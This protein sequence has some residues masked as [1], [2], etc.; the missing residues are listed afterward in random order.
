MKKIA[1]PMLLAAVILACAW[2]VSARATGIAHHPSPIHVP[3]PAP[4]KPITLSNGSLAMSVSTN[5]PN[6]LQ[7][8]DG[9]MILQIDLEAVRA[10]IQ[11]HKPL[12]IALVIDRSG[13]MAERGKL[14]YA[15]K[16]AQE[17]VDRLGK[18]D[19]LA[20]IIYDDV[21][22]VLVPST[23]VKDRE[24]IKEKIAG[25][26]ERGATN[27]AEGL[28]LGYSQ[29]RE[30][31]DREAINQVIILSDGLANRGITGK[32]DI[33]RMVSNWRE[34]GVSVTALGLG[35]DFNEDLMMG[36]A[37]ASGG[38]YN[39]IESPDQLAGIYEKELNTLMATVG[40]DVKI[41]INT[42]EGVKLDDVYGYDAKI[43]GSEIEIPL[44]A[45]DGGQHR[46]IVAH[47]SA[48]TSALGKKDVA[49]VR[50]DYRDM[51]SDSKKVTT[52]AKVDVICVADMAR[53]EEKRNLAVEG[54]SYWLGNS[55]ENTTAI[56]AIEGGRKDDA[57]RW[58][59][60]KV[61]EI[62]AQNAPIQSP[63]LESQAKQ[64]ENDLSNL[65][66][67][68]N[69]QDGRGKVMV[70]KGKELQRLQSL[71]YISQ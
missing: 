61:Q 68:D 57:V 24:W 62:R 31:L 69:L 21:A 5:N 50:L 70:K 59:E 8:S 53:V 28:A 46:I 19:R 41:V 39:F 63:Q 47:L 22:E 27:L 32:G 43:A 36:I 9:K 54:N 4:V 3:N 23:K 38:H 58:Y 44:G 60:R 18:N 42:A 34:E 16:A 25:I 71:G 40:K 2:Y 10:E 66:K 48:P 15:R 33:Q 37:N 51:L 17:L 49:Q 7:N 56:Q 30:Y 6:I 12:N 35:M 64:Y 65:K 26:T 52:I 14:E 29:L 20:V 1:L 67:I 11:G 55:R 45:F 13:S